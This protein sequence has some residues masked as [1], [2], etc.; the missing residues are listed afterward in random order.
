M[1]SRDLDQEE[2]AGVVAERVVDHLE[3]VEVGEHHD[4]RRGD[5]ARASQRV[6][7]PVAQE[8]A[9]GEAGEVVVE[10]LV[11]ERLLEPDPLGDVAD[12]RDVLPRLVP[13]A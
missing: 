3:A 8:R 6:I 9:V 2:V 11:L 10:R 1:R 4:D 7:E 13:R 12:D 5:P